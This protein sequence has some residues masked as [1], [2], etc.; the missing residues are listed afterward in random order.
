MSQPQAGTPR[1]EGAGLRRVWL[2]VVVAA[3]LVAGGVTWRLASDRPY[4][5]HP[6]PHGSAQIDPTAAAA[7]LAQLSSAIHDRDEQAAAALGDGDRSS[8][9]LRAVVRTA[10][11]AHLVDLGLRY[12]DE[13][14]G[15]DDDGRW[16]AAVDTTWRFSGFDRTPSHA[17]VR[18]T[19]VDAPSG[20]R[21]AS[22][23]GGHDRTPLWL[24]G[25]LRVT[26]TSH[27]LVLAA[28][29][30]DRYSQLAARAVPIVRRVLHDWRARLVVEVPRNGRGLDRALAAAR[31]DYANIAAV[32]TTADGSLGAHA[33]VHVFVNPDVFDDLK[34]RG[35]QVVMSHEAVHVA[36]NATQSALPLWLVEGFAD[37][38][39]LRDVRLPLRTTAGQIIAQVGK[40][41]APPHLPGPDEFDTTRTH[42]GA[43]YEAAWLA[44]RM[45]AGQHGE[46]DLVRFYRA[47]QAGSGTDAEVR[48]TFRRAFGESLAG[49]TRQWQRRL[50]SL[51]SNGTP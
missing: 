16:P 39:A 6:E 37:Y 20:V 21:I 22:I 35:A 28:T 42:L 27:T 3:V 12:V 5:A 11:R 2:L 48:A 13:S 38:V 24:Q 41:G 45:L 46:A 26:R 34:P 32:T 18:F 1:R 49:F 4:R 30:V 29:R 19:F 10:T 44:C 40:H 23:G 7:T 8:A 43:S 33:P 31:R 9:V 50:T 25:P 15:L 36:T 47:L 51:A 14:G 17:E